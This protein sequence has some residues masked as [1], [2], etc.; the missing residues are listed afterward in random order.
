MNHALERVRKMAKRY[1]RVIGE[2]PTALVVQDKVYRS[3][4]GSMMLCGSRP[5]GDAFN[6]G[7]HQMVIDGV[8]ILSETGTPEWEV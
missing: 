6:P 7:P 1:E 8:R 3:L 5:V 2:K 4:A